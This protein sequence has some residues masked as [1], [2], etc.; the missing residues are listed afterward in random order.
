M[1]KQS[2]TVLG[3]RG[4]VPVSGSAYSRYGGATTCILVRLNAR[5]IVVDAGTGLLRLPEDVL[6]LPRLSLLLTHPHV[7]HLLGLP[8]SSCAMRAGAQLDIYAAVRNGLD[9]R[10]QLGSLMTPPLWPVQPEQLPSD[11]RFHDLPPAIELDGVRVQTMEGHHPGGVSLL[12]LEAEEK[13]VVIMSD[14]TVTRLPW[15]GLC[16]FARGCELLLCDGQYSEEEWDRR[17]EFGHSTWSA[18]ARL[19]AACGAARLRIIHH[20]PG[21]TDAQLDEAAEA[22]RRLSPDYD[23]AREEE[24]IEL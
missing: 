20:D 1:M 5:P 6:A 16:A 11:I 2:V 23:F 7:D 24:V 17:A 8:I 13:S 21:R 10:A 4:S 18:A 14:C 15:E 12:R 19:A 22:M 9:A 3:A